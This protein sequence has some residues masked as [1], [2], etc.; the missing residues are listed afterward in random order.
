[1]KINIIEIRENPLLKRN[2]IIGIIEHN[3][4][5]TPSKASV[6]AY[7]AKEKKIK[8]KHIEVKRIISGV[9]NTQSRILAYVWKE[10]EVPIIE[11]KKAKEKG[12][13]VKEEGKK[14]ESAEEPKK[15][16]K[17]EEATEEGKK[18]EKKVEEKNKE[19]KTEKKAEEKK[20]G[21][22]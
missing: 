21:E 16:E 19:E 3:G 11:E 10:K 15:E 7:L 20:E 22:K 9:G 8:P 17:K 14:E 4:M 12:A 18:E 6:Q 2:E 5:S 13:E 1:M